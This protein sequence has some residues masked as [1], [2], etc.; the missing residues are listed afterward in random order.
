MK[1]KDIDKVFEMYYN[2][3][4]SASAGATGASAVA[5]VAHNMNS[6]NIIKRKPSKKK[7]KHTSIKGAIGKGIYDKWE[8]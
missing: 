2:I 8:V 7:R 5:S 4:E 3:E 1:A 6:G